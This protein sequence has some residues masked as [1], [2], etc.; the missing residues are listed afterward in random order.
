MKPLF[1]SPTGGPTLGPVPGSEYHNPR[2]GHLHGGVD[3]NCPRRHPIRSGRRGGTVLFVGISQGLGGNK[4]TIDYGQL[5]D[6]R[7]H[8]LTHYHFG[9]KHSPPE[10][11]IIVKTG[12]RLRRG[13]IIGYAG[14]SGNATAVHDHYEHIVDGR[15]I[16][17]LQYL[18]EY[19]VVRRPRSRERYALAYPG[20]IGPDIPH[21]QDLL[22]QAGFNPGPSDS[23]YGPNTLTAVKQF[24]A[25]KGLRVDGIIGRQTW[26]ALLKGAWP[27]HS[28]TVERWRTLVE[29]YWTHVG[30]PV[31]Y[32]LQVMWAE[33]RGLAAA[34]NMAS[35]AAGLFQHLPKYW[36]WRHRE[37]R[38]WWAE[39]DVTVPAGDNIYDP[40]LNIAVAAWLFTQQGW[41]AWS[42]TAQ[43]PKTS[44]SPAVR[45]LGDHYGIP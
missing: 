6:G 15:P 39:R 14:D 32:V 13:Q 36:E 35:G 7:R 25:A 31:D 30:E 26:R 45:W 18:R 2:P 37:A 29:Q 10:D 40:E 12:D 4:A 28:T 20:S 27:M 43:Y 3:L 9:A 1:D 42:A 21:L 19:Q 11:S 5:K 44:W 8:V 16:D 34:C 24:Q 38:R 33:S 41:G 23:I 22:R 17:P